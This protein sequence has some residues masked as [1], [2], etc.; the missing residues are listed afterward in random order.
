MDLHAYEIV[1]LILTSIAFLLTVSDTEMAL[2]NEGRISEIENTT[3]S[4]LLF[5]SAV[6]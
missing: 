4:E 2:S 1:A 5:K 3:G 6:S